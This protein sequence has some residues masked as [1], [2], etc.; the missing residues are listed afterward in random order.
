V[1]IAIIDD[2]ATNL[3]VYASVVARIPGVA[4]KGYQSSVEGLAACTESE[5]DLIVL[6][7]HMPDLDGIEFIQAYRKAKPNA[8]TPIVMITGEL[9]REV[10]RRAL[11]VGA[12]DFLSKPADPFEFV[13]RVRNLLSAVE[14]RRLLEQK[15]AV[16]AGG[17][18]TIINKASDHE[19]ETINMLMR[20]VEYK[21]NRSGMHVQRIGQ[22]A[23]VLA[24][25]LG[26]PQDEQRLLLLAAPMHDV[27]K[28]AVRDSILL[29][30][31]KLSPQEFEEIKQHTLV[32]HEILKKATTPILKLGAEIAL[33]HHERWNGEGYPHGWARDRIPLSARIVAVADALDAML[34]D[35]PYH[36]ALS[37]EAAFQQIKINA[38]LFYDPLV[39][40]SAEKNE[41]ELL[42]I[43][44]TF[45]DSAVA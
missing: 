16:F 41:G 36:M 11:D 21:D 19:V 7:F 18:S 22:Y 8:H 26:R 2:N 35:R 6:D 4:S 3:K 44:S 38:G 45:A 13:A 15:N 34:S 9:D 43:A 1:H 23:A 17:T 12:S 30:P 25:G 32:G 29:K 14:D 37:T 33:S 40:A 5:P 39:A 24:R 10:R 27:G 28:A 31:G 20:A 42:A